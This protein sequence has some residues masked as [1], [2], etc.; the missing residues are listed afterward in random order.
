MSSILVGCFGENPL[1]TTLENIN[2]HREFIDNSGSPKENYDL[3]ESVFVEN[4]NEPYIYYLLSKIENKDPNL[5]SNY[6][7]MGI[8]KFPSDPYLNVT[9]ISREKGLTKPESLESWIKL[10]EIHPSNPIVI[11]NLLRTYS[12]IPDSIKN[13]DIVNHF[14]IVKSIDQIT[15]KFYGSKSNSKFYNYSSGYYDLREIQMEYIKNKTL[16]NKKEKNRLENSPEVINFLEKIEE[17]RKEKERIENEKKKR[18]ERVENEKKRIKELY[19]KLYNSTYWVADIRPIKGSKSNNN[20]GS[21]IEFYKNGI[22]M[23]GNDDGRWG[24]NP[25]VNSLRVGTFKFISNS[26]I[27]ISGFKQSKRN[28]IYK[29]VIKK[30]YKTYIEDPYEFVW[31]SSSQRSS[32]YQYIKNNL[33]DFID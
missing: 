7:D 8:K 27:R 10:S 14:N 30:G 31:I 11:H 26:K 15:D 2:Y 29:V 20:Y 12:I 9:K 3:Y 22:V 13:K 19:S 5:G 32:D 1:E 28:G 16:Y 18:K 33:N 21:F 23:T 17:E 25:V 24:S 6:Y 4:Q